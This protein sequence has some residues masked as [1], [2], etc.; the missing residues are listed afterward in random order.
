MREIRCV[1][2]NGGK[3]VLEQP[4]FIKA[5]E[6]VEWLFGD[7]IPQNPLHMNKWAY[8]PRTLTDLVMSA[9]FSRIELHEARCHVPARDFRLEVYR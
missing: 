8:T 9:G 3:L 1:L 2:R 5:K 4:D 7:P 6:K